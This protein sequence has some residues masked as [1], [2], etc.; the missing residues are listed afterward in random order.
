MRPLGTEGHR[1]A[2]LALLAIGALAATLAFAAS[3]A[4]FEPLTTIGSPGNAAGQLSFP[5]SVAIG[6]NGHLYVPDNGQNRINEFQPNGSFVRGWGW[7]VDTGAAAL[8]TCTTVSTCQNGI[9]GGGAGQLNT[10]TGID[11]D[12][13]GNVYVVEK[14]NHRISVFTA[15]G[16]F[17]GAWGAD[18]VPGGGTGFEPCTATCKA[19]V[20]G[21]AAGEMFQPN[22]VAVAG[23]ALYVT[24]SSN[25]RVNQYTTAGAFTRSWGWGVDTGASAFETC[26]TAS[27]CQAGLAGDGAG[28]LG[29][30]NVN[31]SIGGIAVG[32]GGHVYVATA[33]GRIS[34]FDP[35]APTASM[36][37]RA[38]GWGVDTGASAFEICTTA[39]GCL[40]ALAGSGAGQLTN[41]TGVA[42]TA[43]GDVL[44]TELTGFWGIS[45]RI[46]QF[47]SNGPFVRAFGFD[48]IPGGPTGF[49]ICTTNC[50]AGVA[51]NGLG[52]LDQPLD[53]AVDAC[54]AIWTIDQGANKRLTRYG[55][56]GT[57]DQPPCTEGPRTVSVTKDGTGTGTV[58]SSPPGINCG[59]D[60]TEDFPFN[61][62][63]TLTATP[64]SGS[65]FDGWSGDCASSAGTTCTL[66]IDAAKS[67]AATF[68]P[69]PPAP[70]SD[71]TVTSTTRGRI[72]IDASRS[73]GS[74]FRWDINSDGDNDFITGPEAPFL[75]IHLHRPGPTTITLTTSTCCGLKAASQE[76]VNVL[77]L[78]G[79]TFQTLSPDKVTAASAP[80]FLTPSFRTSNVR[81]CD[82]S[83]RLIFGIVDVR[84]CMKEVIHPGDLPDSEKPLVDDGRFWGVNF[85]LETMPPI[86]EFGG[87]G[88]VDTAQGKDFGIY[89]SY[90]PVHMNGMTLTPDP[91]R[92]ILIFPGI[93]RVASSRATLTYDATAV[94]K[95]ITVQ[96]GPL[97]LSVGTPGTT[98]LLSGRRGLALWSFDAAKD[99]PDI[100]GFTLDGQTQIALTQEGDRRLTELTMAL[101]LPPVLKAGDGKGPN[102]KVTVEA[103]NDSGIQ[104]GRLFLSVPEAYVGSVLLQDLGFT[105]SAAGNADPYCA[106]KWWQATARITFLP[107]SGTGGG[108]DLAPPPAREG[109]AFCGGQFHSAGADV[110]FG[111]PIPPPK[112]APGVFLQHIRFNLQAQQ[113]VIIDGG[114]GIT[115]AKITE[116]DGGLLAAFASPQHPYVI[117]AADGNYT[118]GALAGRRLI[119][120]GFAVGGNV[121]VVIPG[122][123]PEEAGLGLGN[124]YL[125]YSYPDYVAGGGTMHIQTLVFAIDAG[126]GIEASTRTGRFNANAQGKFC[127]LGGLTI[128]GF[129]PCVGGLAWA[130]SRGTVACAYLPKDVFEPGFGYRWGQTVGE[131]GEFEAFLGFAGDGCKPSK[132]WETNVQGARVLAMRQTL[133][134]AP[135]RPADG[136][137]VLGPRGLAPLSF[138]VKKGEQTANVHLDGDGGAPAV[139]ITGPDGE[140]LESVPDQVT[141]GQRLRVLA[142]PKYNATWV[143]VDDAQPGTYTITPLPGSV[144]ITGMSETRPEDDTL[145]ATVSGQGGERVVHYDVGKAGGQL[146]RFYERG[147]ATWHEIGKATSGEGEIRF[148]P[149]PG[150]SGKREIVAQIEVDELA[151]PAV[152]VAEFKAPPPPKA[153]AVKKVRARRAGKRLLVSWKAAKNAA[154]YNV[155]VRMRNGLQ[156]VAHTKRTRLSLRGV[157][158]TQSGVVGVAAVGPL[159]DRGKA[160]SGRFKATKDEPDRRGRFR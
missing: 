79:K 150:P 106:S 88:C 151:G 49:E 90:G 39:S 1:V 32:A 36:F 160:G 122:T 55:E 31:D 7:G 123:E 159:T 80:S 157:P 83:M 44:V 23:A 12:A 59:G 63:V 112:I 133:L 154:S 130:S 52:Q 136:A 104:L 138:T 81:D 17:I 85:L 21:S 6:P 4:A 111:V 108:I 34:E 68:N 145:K 8:E 141:A 127:L 22:S 99:L 152:T 121:K 95:K 155:V 116:V 28:Q 134:A 64:D 13:A 20:S 114:A 125:L 38:W 62:V 5:S 144:G 26:T 74:S 143:G 43:G 15:T 50:K 110:R 149:A 16:G 3:A 97:N 48:V 84:G 30:V 119:S 132:F 72:L 89:A 57:L 25:M 109:V 9:A 140:V 91:G 87:G 2:R 18:V 118:L 41:A 65:S 148:T 69:I 147:E 78:G 103:D 45:D 75:A 46:S 102:G 58:T 107:S 47:A 137:Q 129:E 14:G 11:V 146:V 100:G 51:G 66:G 158:Q 153:G 76:K 156:R 42:T 92:S 98:E 128:A 40:G 131:I 142:Y 67:A 113:P 61:E 124:G 115:A 27:A 135:D 105:Y 120:P 37:V 77:A 60:C 117:K 86:C 101:K 29:G 82:P 35:A 24:D 54:D 33:T 10:P 96:H 139:R 56:P 94:T 19:G 70:V 93:N 126:G 71:F 73:F 53:V